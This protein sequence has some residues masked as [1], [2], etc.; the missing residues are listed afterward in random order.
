[1]NSISFF[2]EDVKFNLKNKTALRAW[3][4]KIVESEGYQIDQINYIFCSDEYLLKIN[5]EH[6]DH[7]YLTDIITFPLSDSDTIEADIFI[8]LDR[9]K[10][11][12]G[13]LNL[14]F[15]DEL[16]R[17]IIHGVLH[18]LGYGDKTSEEKS[19]MRKKEDLC[20]SL[21]DF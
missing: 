4:K 16:H 17:V 1:M 18:L 9:V 8:S 20:L 6:L 2:V 5:K 12:S 10:E 21:R 7:D 14:Y 3:I 13:K 15:L 19:L 11:N